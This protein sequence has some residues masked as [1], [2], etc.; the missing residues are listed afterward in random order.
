MLTADEGRPISVD[1]YP[2][3]TGDPPTGSDQLDKLKTRFRLERVV[4]V[5]DR[6]LL[7][8]THIDLLRTRPG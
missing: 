8:Q 5:G 1:V 2:G 4:A 7:T 6:G 3:N